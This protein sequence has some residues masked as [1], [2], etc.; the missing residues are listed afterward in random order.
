MINKKTLFH[1]IST[2]L[3]KLVNLI[4]MTVP[5]AVIWYRFYADLLWVYFWKRGHWLVILLYAILYFVI[6]RIYEAF[7]ISYTSKAEII[8]SQ[9]LALIEVDVI[10]Y[11][12][13]WLL[14]RHVP[15]VFPMLILLAVQAV[16]ST[17]WTFASQAWYFRVFPADRTVIVWDM[18]EDITHLIERYKLEKKYKVV[19]SV[20]IQECIDDIDM[21]KDADTVFLVGIHSHERNTVAKYCLMHN[22]KA[23]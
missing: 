10:M 12:V 17:V 11:I 19:A 20:N 16:I 23:F 5:F 2:R 21:L 14:I 1:D 6:G 15:A 8:Y 7:K 9:M 13:A 3:L 4:L 22:I 18:R